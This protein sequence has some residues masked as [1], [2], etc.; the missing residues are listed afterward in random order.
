MFLLLSIYPLVCCIEGFLYSCPKVQGMCVCMFACVCVSVGLSVRSPAPLP[1]IL[2][3]LPQV[4]QGF[5]GAPETE[6]DSLIYI[7]HTHTH[8]HAH[9]YSIVVWFSHIISVSQKFPL[10]VKDQCSFSLLVQLFTIKQC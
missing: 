6:W 10:R 9:T 5:H 1:H 4:S 2:V 3:G 7:V 8:P